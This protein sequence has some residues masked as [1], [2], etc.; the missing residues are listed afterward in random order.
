MYIW[1]N[2]PK[3]NKIQLLEGILM[4]KNILD[5]YAKYID[6]DKDRTS[7]NL[8]TYEF[9]KSGE[10]ISQLLTGYDPTGALSVLYAKDTFLYVMK[11]A[12]VSVL[13]L[14][15]DKDALK[16][17][18]EIYQMFHSPDI[19]NI[20]KSV[21]GTINSIYTKITRNH[22]IG[23][24]DFVPT[25]ALKYIPFAIEDLRKLNID[26]F[27][28]GD[29]PGLVTNISTKINVFE[30]MSECLLS[31][32]RSADGLYLCFIN[33]GGTADCY[34]AFMYKSNR[35]IFSINDRVDEMFIGQHAHGRNARWTEDKADGIFPYDYIFEYA[36][37][38]YKGYATEYTINEDKLEFY[39]LEEKV[40]VPIIVAMLLIINKYNG[41]MPEKPVHYI[42]SLTAGTK[43]L[44]EST[45]IMNINGS[46]IALANQSI[47]LS[48]DMTA[49]LN[50]SYA[51]EFKKPEGYQWDG[52]RQ[53]ADFKNFNQKLVDKY[54]SDFV[55]NV[56]DIFNGNV[57]SLT[58]KDKNREYEAEFIGTEQKLRLQLHYQIR[59][60]LADHIK[61]KMMAEYKEFG[62]SKG[63][64]EWFMNS[65]K[66]RKEFL[67]EFAKRAEAGVK[68]GSSTV[69]MDNVKVEIIKDHKDIPH[70]YCHVNTA[71]K[72]IYRGSG[73]N[74][75]AWDDNGYYYCVDETTEK[76][77]TCAFLF[78][79]MNES[80]VA[81]LTGIE[82]NNL[83]TFLHGLANGFGRNDRYNGN[84][85]L[86][87]VDFVSEIESPLDGRSIDS[88]SCR[89]SCALCFAK[90][91][92]NKIRKDN[93]HGKN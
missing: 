23:T 78:H 51:E 49:I 9:H 57:L 32:E 46:E 37:H 29:T 62:G 55:P 70:P 66:E 80:G 92:W 20:E 10:I 93:T 81:F 22:H 24:S 48:Y 34:F 25:D 27:K 36:K 50:G 82:V 65:M 54:A 86:D 3:A 31:I 69:Y 2:I 17:T 39:N 35:T 87:I 7:F 12:T 73:H 18:F 85:L 6:Y 33:A 44:I 15:E 13:K 41:Y 40:Y 59:K 26:V 83:P 14:C 89:L 30:T 42:S 19:A 47:N 38:D 45:E 28:K 1:Y 53:H 61:E 8:S 64:R 77:L 88:D 79:P 16:E 68:E 4:Y 5:K 71:K 60:Q 74:Y 43:E 21:M 75:D 67:I 91:N 72:Y 90:S 76:P 52:E 58:D 84:C 56:A 63:V 11:D